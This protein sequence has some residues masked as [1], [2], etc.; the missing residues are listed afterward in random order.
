MERLF[1]SAAARVHLSTTVTAVR[2]HIGGGYRVATSGSGGEVFDA[3][4][5]AAPFEHSALRL[6]AGATPP[7]PRAPFEH[8]WV[9]IVHATGLQPDYF[10]LPTGTKIPFRK[11]TGNLLVMYMPFLTDCL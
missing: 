1:E 6:P 11:Y 9:T 4:V 7:S 3:V 2:R 8:I 5:L 10:G